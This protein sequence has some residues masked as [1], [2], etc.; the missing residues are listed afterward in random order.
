MLYGNEL[1]SVEGHRISSFE[2]TWG[3]SGGSV[4]TLH[5]HCSCKR[6]FEGSSAISELRRFSEACSIAEE[7]L[8]QEGIE[9]SK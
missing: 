7:H 1:P 5:I 4:T 9:L 2:T 3:C 6:L 8:Q